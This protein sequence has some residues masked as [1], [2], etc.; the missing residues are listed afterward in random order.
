MRARAA[1]VKAVLGQSKFSAVW[2]R[3]PF[4]SG[5]FMCL[6]LRDTNAEQFR[7]RLLEEY[8][9]G[10]IATGKKDI[11]VAFSCIEEQ[12]IPEFF[13]TMFTCARDMKPT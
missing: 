1:R 8:G 11:R 10:V 7:L 12:D 9:T 4:N 2:T 3:Y 13:E 5:Y 6:R